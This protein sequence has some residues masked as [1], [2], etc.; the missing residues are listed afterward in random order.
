[1]LHCCCIADNL[2][3]ACPYH[4]HQVNANTV[5]YQCTSSK[6]LLYRQE[7]AQNYSVEDGCNLALQA[8]DIF[9]TAELMFSPSS[10]NAL[11]VDDI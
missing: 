11:D 3:Q 5:Q 9:L 1:M 10:E 7:M 6:Y 4:T 2:Q 8:V